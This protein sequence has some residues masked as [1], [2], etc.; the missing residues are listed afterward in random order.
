M[1]PVIAQLTMTLFGI[2]RRSP[3]VG[4]PSLDRSTRRFPR[5]RL[6]LGEANPPDG[7]QRRVAD[8]ISHRVPRLAEKRLKQR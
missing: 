4:F 8:D 1:D 5:S 6:Q 2:V 3:L 7:P